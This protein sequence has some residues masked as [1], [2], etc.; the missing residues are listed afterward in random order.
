MFLN[1]SNAIVYIIFIDLAVFDG[2]HQLISEKPCRPRHFE[3]KSAISGGCR[4]VYRKPVGHDE[5]LESPLFLED[6]VQQPVIFRG[7]G[8]VYPVIGAHHRPA[9]GFPDRFFERRE[10]YFPDS[11]LLDLGAY[12]HTLEFRVVQGEMLDAGT[13]PLTL[14]AIDKRH[15]NSGR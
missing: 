5:S 7:I 2:F 11:A 12:R 10:V 1:L 15:G 3:V 4:A 13:H 8:A 14:D 9:S 6:I